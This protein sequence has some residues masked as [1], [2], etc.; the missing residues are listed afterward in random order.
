MR[1]IAYGLFL[2]LMVITGFMIMFRTSVSPRVV[3][4]FTNALPRI[5]LGLVLI[6]FSFPIIGFIID[7]GA[8]FASELIGGIVI[9]Q[10]SQIPDI[11]AISSA[12]DAVSAILPVVLSNLIGT[13]KNVF[14]NPPQVII[15]LII[16]NIF[17]LTAMVIFVLTLGRVLISYAWLL[18]YT[19]FSPLLILF[20]SLPGQEGKLADLGKKIVAKTLVFP[21]FVFFVGLGLFFASGAIFGDVDFSLELGRWGNLSTALQSSELIFSAGVLGSLL[22]LVMLAAAW[23]APAMIEDALGVGGKPPK[24]K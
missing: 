12:A 19:L 13:L 23:K 6:T 5:V 10:F 16:M 3:V 11:T 9:T 2:V 4:T 21:S 7:I 17:A 15:S 22:S 18:I 20:G 14:T 1:N 24:K 8:V